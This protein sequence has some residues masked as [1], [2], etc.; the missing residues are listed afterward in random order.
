MRSELLVDELEG[1]MGP[2]EVGD[3][4]TGRGCT[5]GG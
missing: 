1:D 5:M 3:A 4:T 2:E